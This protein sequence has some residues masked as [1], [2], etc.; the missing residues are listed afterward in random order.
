MYPFNT[1]VC[2]RQ[3]EDNV[4]GGILK[5]LLGA[6]ILLLFG[7][8][9]VVLK[10]LDCMLNNILVHTYYS[11]SMSLKTKCYLVKQFNL[12]MEPRGRVLR[13]EMEGLLV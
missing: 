2:C 11:I 9:C 7:V 3:I 4:A 13:L 5:A 10:Y 1:H 8:Q 6:Q 12:W